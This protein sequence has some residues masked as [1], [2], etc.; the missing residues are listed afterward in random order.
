[1][2]R[3]LLQFA[4]VLLLFGCRQMETSQKE[5]SMMFSAG[6]CLPAS[7]TKVCTDMNSAGDIPVYWE[8]GDRIRIM[9]DRG[10]SIHSREFRRCERF[11][12]RSS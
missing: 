7:T 8:T 3:L 11:T 10:E 2:K 9:D 1:M 5:A 6:I 4:I 12:I